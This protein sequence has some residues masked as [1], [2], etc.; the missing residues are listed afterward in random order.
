[1]KRLSKSRMWE[2][3]LSGSVRGLRF[4]R[5]STPGDLLPTRQKRNVVPH[6]SPRR[7]KRGGWNA[8]GTFLEGE[9][10]REP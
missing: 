7:E 9:R 1:M 2:S 5:D 3:C 6:G 10:P 8:C 4:N